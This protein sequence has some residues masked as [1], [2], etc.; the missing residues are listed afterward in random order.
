[1]NDPQES[2]AGQVILLNG[3][4]SAGK[5]T[6]AQAIQHVARQP[7]FIISLDQFRDGLPDRYR[8]LNAPPNTTGAEG[9]NVRAERQGDTVLTHIEFGDYGLHVLKGM[10]RTVATCAGIGLNV[11]VDDM[12]TSRELMIDYAHV[13]HNL[14]VLCVG[15]HCDEKELVAREN[16]RPGRFA[17]TAISHIEAVHQYVVY[18]LEV[19]NT[20]GDPRHHAEL[21]LSRTP[22]EPHCTAI[23]E[24]W[25]ALGLVDQ[26]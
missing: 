21:I 16:A 2:T 17:G 14:P 26:Q 5:S 20:D 22:T 8:G 4:S 18:D 1:M 13:L 15:I 24:M 6:I 10:H 23:E 19:D 11:I 12:I 9:L 25:N 7:Y 3:T